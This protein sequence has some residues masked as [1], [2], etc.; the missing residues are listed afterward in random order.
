VT[1]TPLSRS[2]GQRSRS[3]VKG[4]RSLCRF[5]HCGVTALTSCSAEHGNVLAVGTYCY[6]AVCILQARSARRR[7]ALRR[8]QREERGGAYCGGR[9]PSAC[10]IF[11]TIPLTGNE[12]VNTLLYCRDLANS[13]CQDEQRAGI[14][15]TVA[16]RAVPDN[17]Y[18]HRSGTVH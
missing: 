17:S 4:Q 2:K 14:H 6:V 9:P 15:T 8:P 7:E 10:C 3:L 11:D 18:D 12:Q 16:L 1:R 5:T 13:C